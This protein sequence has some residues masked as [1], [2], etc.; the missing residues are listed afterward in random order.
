MEDI[1]LH[2]LDIVENATRAG[3]T[4]VEV[5][6]V[7]NREQDLFQIIIRDNGKGMDDDMVNRVRDPFTTTKTERRVGLGIPMLEQAATEAEGN[8]TIR[9]M[10]N[11]GTEIIATFKSSHIDRKPLGDLGSTLIT[12]IMGNPDIDFVL[13]YDSDGEETVVDTR[14]IKSELDEVPITEPAVLKMI[15]DLF[16]NLDNF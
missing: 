1:S 7:N 9:S 8:L 14:E 4:L 6:I 10:R 11:Q 3:A 16:K 15:R 5:K 2:I 13:S 12:L